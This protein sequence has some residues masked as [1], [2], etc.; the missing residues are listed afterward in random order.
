[1]TPEQEATFL[2]LVQLGLPQ[3]QAAAKVGFTG[4]A[5]SNRKRRDKEF[6]RRFEQADAGAMLSVYAHL[7]KAAPKDWRAA[8]AIL[9]RRWPHVW[10]KPESKARLKIEGAPSATAVAQSVEV[11]RVCVAATPGLCVSLP[12]APAVA[13]E[14]SPQ[15]GSD[16]TTEPSP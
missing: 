9:E 5:I 16:S 14:T 6:R 2:Q 8:L 10:G 12:D 13:I 3:R 7:L 11:W 1:M 4:N 15:E